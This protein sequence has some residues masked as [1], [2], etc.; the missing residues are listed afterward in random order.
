MVLRVVVLLAMLGS[1]AIAD[2]DPD[3]AKPWTAGKSKAEQDAAFHLY[4]EAN[5]LFAKGEYVK[6]LE[7]YDAAL[8]AWDHPGIR[9][10]RA[11][12]LINL[13]RTVE[14]YQDLHLALKYGE[15]PIGKDL[16]NEGLNYQKLLA[17]QVAEIEIVASD[18]GAKISVDGKPL[19]LTAG[20]AT[21]TLA[22]NAPHEITAA[23]PG[24]QTFR[25]PLDRLPPGQTTRI[26][27]RLELLERGRWKPWAV[28]AGGAVISGVG[29]YAYSLARSDL[30]EYEKAIA[31]FCPCTSEADLEARGKIAHDLPGSA[32]T[33]EIIA[34]SALAIGGATIATGIVLVIRGRGETHVAPAV[35]RDSAGVSLLGR[36]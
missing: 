26:D 31:N 9:Y 7:K 12:C 32:H 1:V 36:W 25:K 27:I 15:E 21:L 30:D 8:A 6:A 4:D 5:E 3:G 19:A 20:R 10:N 29:V 34:Y 14:A 2:G 17:K 23:K 22:T 13:D 24:Y 28:I 35:S 18:K 33:K 16:Y 11:V